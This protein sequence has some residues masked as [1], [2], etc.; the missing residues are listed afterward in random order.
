ML[1]GM[2]LYRSGL[3]NGAWSRHALKATM[4]GGIGIGG[5]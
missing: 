1:I 3:W 4:I 5:A 2:G